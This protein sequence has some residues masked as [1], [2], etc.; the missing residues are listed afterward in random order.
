MPRAPALR[1]G[2]ARERGALP[3]ARRA[4]A[5]CSRGK[6]TR[7]RGSSPTSARRLPTFSATRSTSGTGPVSGSITSIPTIAS[8]IIDYRRQQSAT[9]RRL[10]VRVPNARGR[11]SP[12]VVSGRRPRDPR[13]RRTAHA[14]R[15]HDRHHRSQA[16][17][18]GAAAAAARARPPGQEHALD[19][20]GGG[21]ADAADIRRRSEASATRSAAESRRWRACTRPSGATRVRPFDCASWPSCRSRPSVARASAPRSMATR[22]RSQCSRPGRSGSSCTSWRPTPSSTARSR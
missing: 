3:D 14:A 13:R 1:G 12:G 6:P 17:R 15:L 5:I 22:C 7:A 19:R 4:R 20:A 2:A 11:R 16:R 10:R 21:R 9:R 18:R 8:A